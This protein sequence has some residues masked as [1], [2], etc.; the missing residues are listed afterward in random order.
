MLAAASQ[1]APRHSIGIETGLFAAIAF[2]SLLLPTRASA[3][4][5]ESL[6]PL[7][8]LRDLRAFCS[9]WSCS[10][11]GCSPVPTSAFAHSYLTWRGPPRLALCCSH[12]PGFSSV[13]NSGASC[14]SP[15]ARSHTSVAG[16]L[17]ALRRAESRVEEAPY[18]RVYVIVYSLWHGVRS[19]STPMRPSTSVERYRIRGVG[20]LTGP[21]PD[22]ASA[23][24]SRSEVHHHRTSRIGAIVGHW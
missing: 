22:C 18:V 16:S 2:M 6:R 17:R 20:S 15:S 9:C 1:L 14:P 4:A 12:P 19:R 8:P 11:A 10:C 24:H 7:R 3:G 23:L 13:G 21:P 5:P